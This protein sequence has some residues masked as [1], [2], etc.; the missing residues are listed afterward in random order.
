MI[1]LPNNVASPLTPESDEEK[2]GDAKPDDAKAGEDKSAVEAKSAQANA[3]T[4][5]RN[6]SASILTS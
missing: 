2:A 5:H 6:P 3:P 4:L 1:V